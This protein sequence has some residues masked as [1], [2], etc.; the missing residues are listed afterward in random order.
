MNED[1]A[2][3]IR[4][5]ARQIV[6]L[7]QIAAFLNHLGA[8][9]ACMLDLGERCGQ[10]HHDG[11]GNAQ[12]PGMIGDPLGM[13]ARAHRR[14]SARLFFRRQRQKAIERAALLEAG[15]ELAVLEFQPH[16]AAGD[17]RQG[18]RMARG[19]THQRA[20]RGGGGGLH[21][22]KGNRQGAHQDEPPTRLRR[23]FSCAGAG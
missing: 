12:P 17:L 5:G 21:I 7:R 19:R 22:F 8:E 16:I 6:G 4:D 18:H 15:G 9:I 3:A 1:Q 14:H 23:P 2:L 10:R 13:V 11:G 20:F